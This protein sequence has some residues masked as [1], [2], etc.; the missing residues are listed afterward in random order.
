MRS[1]QLVML[2]AVMILALVPALAFSQ[3]TMVSSEDPMIHS[4]ETMIE[5]EP[6]EEFVTEDWLL[7][8]VVTVDAQNSR[9]IVSYIDEKTEEE[10]EISL[11][12]DSGTQYENVDSLDEIEAG[13]VVAI[14]YILQPGGDAVALNI[15][16]EEPEPK[17]TE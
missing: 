12:V 16:I 10:K 2:L 14:D 7:G 1:N 3:G 9:L 13:S 8:D 15:R 5:E 11:L 17:M 6:G 4:Q